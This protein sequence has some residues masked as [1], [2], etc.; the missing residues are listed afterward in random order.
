M[1]HSHVPTAVKHSMLDVAALTQC[2][3]FTWL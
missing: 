1:F 2:I 3:S